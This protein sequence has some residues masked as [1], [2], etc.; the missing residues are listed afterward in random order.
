MNREE[1]VA[2][3]EVRQFVAWATSTL[4]SLAIELHVS[5]KGTG[6]T[7]AG[8]GPGVRGRF[9]GIDQV[10]KAYQWHSEFKNRDGDL[11]VS[12]DLRSTQCAFEELRTWLAAALEHQDSEELIR[13]INSVL[14]WGGDIAYM[15]RKPAGALPFLMGLEDLPGYLLKLKQELALNHADTGRLG[16]VG[17]M[18][19]MLTKVHALLADDGLPIYDSRVAGAIASIVELYRRQSGAGWNEVPAPLR[20]KATDRAKRSRRVPGL[21]C[22]AP[23]NDGEPI[24]DPGVLSRSSRTGSLEWASCKVRLGWLMAE[25]LSMDRS[26]FR[27]SGGACDMRA[28]MHS[29]EASLFMIGFNVSSL[30]ENIRPQHGRRSLTTNTQRL[31]EI[32]YL[33]FAHP[34]DF[35][36]PVTRWVAVWV[37]LH[38]VLGIDE[39]SALRKAV[40]IRHLREGL[41]ALA[42]K[43][44]LYSIEAMARVCSD[45]LDTGQ[46]SP[47]FRTMNS[48]WMRPTLEPWISQHGRPNSALALTNSSLNIW[49]STPTKERSALRK[50]AAKAILERLGRGH[51]ESGS[52]AWL[53]A[54]R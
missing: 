44:R 17:H 45:R 40:P 8:F 13:A 15:R 20:F 37:A 43:G 31:E 50:W 51:F 14:T 6:R 11:F 16:A 9:V 34:G 52:A 28:C 1:F 39:D 53:D 35:S 54:R 38:D 18:N 25:I 24:L 2:H 41:Q 33:V 7:S 32:P 22:A 19:A 12:S 47:E 4:P 49:R 48:T 46:A 26:L 5:P 36:A 3:P 29:F 23:H 10:A 27:E 30:R 21:R 42:V